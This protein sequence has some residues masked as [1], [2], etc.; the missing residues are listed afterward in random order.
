MCDERTSTN[1][2]SPTSAEKN[3][4]LILIEFLPNL[5]GG[6]RALYRTLELR[7]ALDVAGRSPG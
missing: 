6:L 2:P 7:V 4:F 3:R 5:K 1:N